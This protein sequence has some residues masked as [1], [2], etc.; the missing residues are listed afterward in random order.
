MYVVASLPT[1]SLNVHLFGRVCQEIAGEIN[2][3]HAE[4]RSK[5]QYSVGQVVMNGP[6]PAVRQEVR[7]G[8]P[9]RQSGQVPGVWHVN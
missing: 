3:F 6:Y 5:L 8:V 2:A 9:Q 4:L 1:E 7:G